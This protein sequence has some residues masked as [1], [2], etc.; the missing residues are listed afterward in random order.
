MSLT[1]NMDEAKYTICS[2]CL[3]PVPVQSVTIVLNRWVGIRELCTE[4]NYIKVDPD[5]TST[6][7]PFPY[8]HP[9]IGRYFAVI[10]MIL[11]TKRLL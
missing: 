1:F 5:N 2:M 8:P 10:M 7:S 4:C 6:D 3:E 9:G 11:Y